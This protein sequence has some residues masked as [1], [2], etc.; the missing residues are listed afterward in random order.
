MPYAL[1]SVIPT[2]SAMSRRRT[3]GSWAMQ[4][5]ALAWLVRKLQ[6]SMPEDYRQN[7]R[8]FVLLFKAREEVALMSDCPRPAVQV[9]QRGAATSGFDIAVGLFLVLLVGVMLLRLG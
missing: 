4:T 5:R 3:P 9:I 2:R 7:S 1:R 6:R 8:N